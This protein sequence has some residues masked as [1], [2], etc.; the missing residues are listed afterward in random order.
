MLRRVFGS[1]NVQRHNNVKAFSLISSRDDGCPWN[2]NH[3]QNSGP[4][5]PPCVKVSRR[6]ASRL[7]RTTYFQPYGTARKKHF[8][9]ST[10]FAFS[11]TS[12]T[13]ML[14]RQFPGQFVQL[15]LTQEPNFVSRSRNACCAPS[16]TYAPLASLASPFPLFSISHFTFLH[17]QY[18]LDRTNLPSSPNAQYGVVNCSTIWFR[19]ILIPSPLP[20]MAPYAP[21]KRASVR[22]SGAILEHLARH[23]SFPGHGS[24]QRYLHCHVSVPLGNPGL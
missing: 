6:K 17:P 10:P 4:M 9:A 20:H 11:I 21:S 14:S 5:F 16:L 15:A 1:I 22:P 2:A 12:S 24:L 18:K 8:G 19:P 3:A 7:L 13:H 23:Q